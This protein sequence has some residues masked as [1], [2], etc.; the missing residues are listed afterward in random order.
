MLFYASASKNYS[1]DQSNCFDIC[2]LLDIPI[3]YILNH[4]AFTL[5]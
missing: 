5:M 4:N 2:T 3:I 1:V